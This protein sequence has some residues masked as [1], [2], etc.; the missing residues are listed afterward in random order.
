[1]R[2][3][4]TPNVAYGQE[5][6]PTCSL[7]IRKR[8]LQNLINTWFR[9]SYYFDYLANNSRSDIVCQGD[10]EPGERKESQEG[11]IPGPDQEVDEGHEPWN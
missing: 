7:V 3:F 9:G 10:E 4:L 11:R 6:W 8:D 2:P 5:S 1:M